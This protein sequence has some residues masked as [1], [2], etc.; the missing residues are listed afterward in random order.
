MRVASLVAGGRWKH[1]RPCAATDSFCSPSHPAAELRLAER[2]FLA[3]RGRMCDATY[4]A[5]ITG[6]IRTVSELECELALT[7]TQID[8]IAALTDS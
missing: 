3:Y 6:T 4:D 5:W 7:R 2:A 8:S 1:L